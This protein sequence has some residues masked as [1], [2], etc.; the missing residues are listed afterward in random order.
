MVYLIENMEQ[1]G[2]MMVMKEIYHELNSICG[3]SDVTKI[4]N[5]LQHA[6]SSLPME[7]ADS[8]HA[9]TLWAQV[10]RMY[11]KGGLHAYHQRCFV[12]L[13]L[14]AQARAQ[15]IRNV[16]QEAKHLA[17]TDKLDII[18]AIKTLLSKCEKENIEIDNADELIAKR[19]K[20]I[21]DASM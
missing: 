10:S 21:K 13:S 14:L 6:C 8:E 19:E 20:L 18:F 12:T 17:T 1:K 2:S 11:I 3:T 5:V 4:E 15:D 16:R 7:L 9:C